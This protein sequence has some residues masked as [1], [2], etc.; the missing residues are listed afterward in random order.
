MSQR[1]LWQFHWGRKN[2]RLAFRLFCFPG[3]FFFPFLVIYNG[4]YKGRNAPLKG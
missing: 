2:V 3:L 1:L 4:D